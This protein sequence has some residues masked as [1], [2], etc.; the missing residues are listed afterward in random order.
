MG[1]LTAGLCC[2]SHEELPPTFPTLRSLWTDPGPGPTTAD[3]LLFFSSAQKKNKHGA[4]WCS[5]EEWFRLF[6]EV[7]KNHDSQI[8]SVVEMNSSVWLTLDGVYFFNQGSPNRGTEGDRNLPVTRGGKGI[9]SSHGA[10]LFFAFNLFPKSVESEQFVCLFFTRDNPPAEVVLL[11]SLSKSELSSH[12]EK[13]WFPLQ[14][15]THRGQRSGQNLSD[16]SFRRRQLQLHVHLHH[17]YVALVKNFYP[18]ETSGLASDQCLL[19]VNVFILPQMIWCPA[20]PKL[21]F[22]EPLHASTGLTY[23]LFYTLL[24]SV[25]LAL[26][27]LIMS[28][29]KPSHPPPLTL[30]FSSLY[31]SFLTPPT[32]IPISSTISVFPGEWLGLWHAHL[33]LVFF[34]LPLSSAVYLSV[35]LSNNLENVIKNPKPFIAGLGNVF[36]HVDV[37]APWGLMHL[38]HDSPPLCVRATYISPLCRWACFLGGFFVPMWGI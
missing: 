9:H 13:V 5:S 27:S 33:C 31:I 24:L 17:R 25:F 22:W 35:S 21:V 4:T 32:L 16:Y 1:C 7:G 23:H 12:G 29:S 37:S 6:P 2:Y 34:A 15:V 11:P 36:I 3:G 20:V 14:T 38:R 18:C 30:S 28:L 19:N 10:T 8:H 26:Y